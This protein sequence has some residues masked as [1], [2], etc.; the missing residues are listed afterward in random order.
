MTAELASMSTLNR[1][2]NEVA[3]AK[4]A[5][6]IRPSAALDASMSDSAKNSPLKR[7]IVAPSSEDF[8]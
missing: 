7:F 1:D 3:D 6:M 5:S 8:L 2:I 4:S